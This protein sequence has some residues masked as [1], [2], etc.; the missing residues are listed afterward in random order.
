[1]KNITNNETT[2]IV[3]FS[4]DEP[5]YALYLNSVERVI[6]AVAITPLPNSLEKVIGIINMQGE[7]VPV[8]DIRKIF[9]LPSHELNIDDQFIIAKTS[10]RMVALVVDE[11]M[12]VTDLVNEKIKDPEKT[13]PFADYLNGISI[14]ENNIILIT[15]LEKFLSL[16]EEILL[17][18][19]MKEAE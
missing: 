8:I 14:F 16:E 9:R 12:G 18:Q 19:A 2:K 3:L 7:I 6:H 11:V 1:M 4:L 13:L 17:D 15:D 5:R 10:K